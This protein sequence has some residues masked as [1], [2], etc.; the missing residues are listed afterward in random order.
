M[1]G[2]TAEGGLRVVGAGLPR[3][4]T[5]SLQ[6]ALRQLLG[7]ECYH[8]H[9]VFERAY[10]DVPAWQAALDGGPVDWPAL[11][12]G[13]A[14]AVDWPASLFWRELADRYPDAVVLLSVRDDAQAWW[15]SADRTVWDVMRKGGPGGDPDWYRMATGVMD[16]VFG[17][18]WDS[19]APA[20]AAYEA[21]ND[22]VRAACPPGRLLEWNARQ[23]WEPICRRLGLP[24]PD[25]E[26]PRVN[27]T[28]EWLARNESP[29]DGG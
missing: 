14:A 13:C 7:A 5:R 10:A 22:A 8:M 4:G 29:V 25:E 17:P 27:T 6:F 15:R 26:F 18:D 20:M 11:F 21:W 28:E 23:G 1:D 12:T 9:V 19:P 3:T 16:R 2:V 24:V